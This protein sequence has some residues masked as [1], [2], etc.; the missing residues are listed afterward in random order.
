MAENWLEMVE[1]LQLGKA[2]QD[3]YYWRH[4]L[5]SSIVVSLCRPSEKSDFA[6]PEIFL[7]FETNLDFSNQKSGCRLKGR[8]TTTVDEG[9]TKEIQMINRLLLVIVIVL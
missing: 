1:K 2:G 7:G 5:V 3:D 4:P 6:E 9:G 8:L